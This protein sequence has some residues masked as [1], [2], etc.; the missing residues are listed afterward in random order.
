MGI[1]TRLDGRSSKNN[2]LAIVDSKTLEVIA[3]IRVSGAEAN[4]ELDTAE[5][6]HI[7]KSNGA[8]LRRK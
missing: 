5:N 3:T 8:V 7:A 4:L 1:K 6:I 2:S